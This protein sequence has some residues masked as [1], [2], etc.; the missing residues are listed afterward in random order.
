MESI[1]AALFKQA[2][3]QFASGV[4][5]MTTSNGKEDWG[6]TASAF[7]SLSLD[8]P[9]VLV[10]VKKGN[11]MWNRLQESSGYGVS[12]LA[13]DQQEWS[14]RFAGGMVDSEGNWV[15]WPEDRSRFEGI[16]FSR[17]DASGAPLLPG[18]L[19]Q[20][21]CMHEAQLDGGDHTIFVGRVVHANAIGKGDGKPL[22]YHSGGYQTL[23]Q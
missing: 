9:L 23:N 3:G 8:P 19:A 22:V 17:G 21:D 5:V 20:L 15:S 1:D 6:M 10:C 12:V 13:E 11:T 7:S 2:L 14:N 18:A 16:E 4:T